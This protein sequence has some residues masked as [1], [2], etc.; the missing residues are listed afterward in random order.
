MS[1][2]EIKH[3]IRMLPQYRDYL[4][5]NRQSFI[6]RI[7]GI[8]TV[9]IDKFSSL[10]VMLMQN[11]LPAVKNSE[12]VYLFDLKGSTINRAELKDID[13]VTLK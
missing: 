13:T 1:E 2:K 5:T 6:A 7:Y 10:H 3:M 9:S 12:I 8:F 11:T 4:D